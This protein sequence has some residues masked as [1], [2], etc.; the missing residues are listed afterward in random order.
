MSTLDQMVAPLSYAARTPSTRA[1]RAATTAPH[2]QGRPDR[3]VLASHPMPGD[4]RALATSVDLAREARSHESALMLAVAGETFYRGPGL[5]QTEAAIVAIE[6]LL[7]VGREEGVQ[8]VS[9][10]RA[11][12]FLKTAQERAADALG[13]Q[14]TSRPLAPAAAGLCACGRRLTLPAGW[15]EIAAPSLSCIPCGPASDIPFEA[16]SARCTPAGDLTAASDIEVSLSIPTGTVAKLVAEGRI[17]ALDSTPV[18]LFSL[19]QVRE[20][21]ADRHLRVV[22]ADR[23]ERVAAA[24]R[25]IA[26]G[27]PVAE[28]AKTAGVSRATLHRWFAAS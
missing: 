5:A 10:P 8:D 27:V 21:V 14:T 18:A 19:S 6:Q 22:G 1:R 28:A 23:E 16:W 9:L 2:R 24:R 26:A 13:L 25:S 15:T 11:R 17:E 7:H 3:Q 12:R 4:E 20:V